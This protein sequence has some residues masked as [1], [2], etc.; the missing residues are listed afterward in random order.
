MRLIIVA[1]LVVIGKSFAVDLPCVF[2]FKVDS[3]YICQVVNFT[4]TNRQAYVTRVTGDHRQDRS[5]ESVVRVTMFNASIHYLPGNLTEIFPQLRVLLVKKCGMKGLTRATEFHGLRKIYFGFNEIDRIPV[6]YFWHFCK[7][8]ILSLYGNRISDIPKMAFRDLISLERLS[9]NNNRLKRLA[10]DLFDNCTNLVYI[11][12]DNNLLTTLD[13]RLFADRLKLTRIY[14]RHN[15][16]N[17]IDDDFLATLTGLQF[18]L[19]QNNT[20]INESF[21]EMP[22]MSPPSLTPL[23]H[24]QSVFK[25][26]CTP[27]VMITSSTIAPT[28]TKPRKKPEFSKANIYYFEN[29]KW[30]APSN[31]RY[32]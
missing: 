17:S 12:L 4:N 3:G 27:P 25:L 14:L 6:N 20:C 5:L 24:I 16:I 21:P 19:F 10:P 32:Y 2:D 8:Q 29:C 23:A 30:H 22:L 11:D 1:F 9:L 18:A 28:T 7:L 15:Q 31:N 13:G 26:N